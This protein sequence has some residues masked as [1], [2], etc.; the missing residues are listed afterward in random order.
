MSET[1]PTGY[2]DSPDTA[3]PG[4]AGDMVDGTPGH[5][6]ADRGERDTVLVTDDEAQRDDEVVRPGNV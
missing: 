1:Q 6:A 3:D 2:G 5:D 4:T